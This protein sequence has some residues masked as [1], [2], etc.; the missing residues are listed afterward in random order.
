METATAAATLIMA[1]IYLAVLAD[2][3]KFAALLS[4][5]NLESLKPINKEGL[6]MFLARWRIYKF[7]LVFFPIA[8]FAT[9]DFIHN[10]LRLATYITAI[11]IALFV[12]YNLLLYNIRHNLPE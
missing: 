7:L 1:A 12:M 4:A 9:S 11:S 2:S 3:T 5:E 8:S 10:G 6:L